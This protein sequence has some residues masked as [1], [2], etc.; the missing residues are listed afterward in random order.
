M[1]PL[2]F[3]RDVLADG[4]RITNCNN[5]YT[6]FDL[7]FLDLVAVSTSPLIPLYFDVLFHDEIQSLGFVK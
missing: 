6:H 5:I 2:P 1:L 7:Q 3:L 4:R